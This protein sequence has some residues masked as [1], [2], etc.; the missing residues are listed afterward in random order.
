MCILSDIYTNECVRSFIMCLISCIT[1]CSTLLFT[2]FVDYELNPAFIVVPN[3]I[4]SDAFILL[5]CSL[6]TMHV[7]FKISMSRLSTV[8]EQ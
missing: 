6:S 4:I 5:T 3:T 1:I 7:I 8:Y 2:V